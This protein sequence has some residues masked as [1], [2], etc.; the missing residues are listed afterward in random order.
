M[1]KATMRQKEEQPSSRKICMN[2][3]KNEYFVYIFRKEEKWESRSPRWEMAHQTN[4]MKYAIKRAKVLY[5]SNKFRRVEVKKKCFNASNDWK[6]DFTIKSFDEETKNWKQ[7][8]EAFA[9][10]GL[11]IAVGGMALM[12]GLY[13][14]SNI[15]F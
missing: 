3:P 2:H 5:Q 13:H 1:N 6:A 9:L 8:K 10:I 11:G 4:N 12:L 14:F 7:G 15:T